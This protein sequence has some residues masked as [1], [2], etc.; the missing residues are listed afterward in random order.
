MAGLLERFERLRDTI[1]ETREEADRFFE[2]RSV[3][4]RVEADSL[5]GGNEPELLARARGPLPPGTAS[6]LGPRGGDVDLGFSNIAGRASLAGTPPSP[7][8][9]TLVDPRGR[10]IPPSAPAPTDIRQSSTGRGRSGGP[11][12]ADVLFSRG[13]RPAT[14]EFLGQYCTPITISVPNPSNR[15]ALQQNDFVDVP[16]WDCR[17][18]LG[19]DAIYVD[20]GD[21]GTLRLGASGVGGSGGGTG[22]GA[23]RRTRG[24]RPQHTTTAATD[25]DGTVG[26]IGAGSREGLATLRDIR[27]DIREI[28]R[29]RP[30]DGEVLAR[31]AGLR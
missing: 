13:G 7:P 29:Q 2:P 8:P 15:L 30:E 31:V 3:A 5:L 12:D 20:S 22:G 11:S 14:R 4:L 23:P 28:R 1:R 18:V 25:A 24:L 27:D 10:P 9:G 6:G 21:T 16:G 26:N 19:P 17:E